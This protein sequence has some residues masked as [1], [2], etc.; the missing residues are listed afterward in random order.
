MRNIVC[1]VL[2]IYILCMIGRAILGFFPVSQS[3]PVA[4]IGNVLFTITEPLLGPLRRIIPRVG[5]FDLSFLVAVIVL[6]VVQRAV[7]G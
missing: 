5:M 3:G 6:Q 1:S 4:T 2:Q 7:C